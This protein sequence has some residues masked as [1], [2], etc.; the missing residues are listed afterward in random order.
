[1]QSVIDIYSSLF[2]VSIGAKRPERV[3]Y[4]MARIGRRPMRAIKY[5]TLEGTFGSKSDPEKTAV[6]IFTYRRFNFKI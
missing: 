1:M 4:F 6:C 2:W 5:K 3:L